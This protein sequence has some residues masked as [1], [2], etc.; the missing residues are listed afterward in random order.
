MIDMRE[1]W[2]LIDAPP[3]LGHGDPI[4]LHF[5]R[6]VRIPHGNG[7][8]GRGDLLNMKTFG[9][10]HDN[11]VKTS[12]MRNVPKTLESYDHH[13]PLTIRMYEVESQN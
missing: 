13:Q 8:W 10:I 9:Q 7:Q 5:L 3:I 11:Y 12:K 6:I 4:G 1:Q 2:E